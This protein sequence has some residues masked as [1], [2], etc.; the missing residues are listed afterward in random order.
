[1][2]SVLSWIMIVLLAV[3]L[4]ACVTTKSP[5][6]ATAAPAHLKCPNCGFE[7]DVSHP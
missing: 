4:S 1:M 5:A 6:P 3:S 2:K 7:F